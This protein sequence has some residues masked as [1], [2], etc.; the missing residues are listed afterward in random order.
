MITLESTRRWY[1]INDPVH[2]Y[3]HIERVY[4]MAI[5]LAAAEGADMGIV[6]AASLLHDVTSDRSSD[7]NSQIPRRNHQQVASE[8]A[9]QILETEGWSEARI[10]AV[11]HCI[12]AHRFRD[13]TQQP[14]TLEAK[15]IFD[16]DKL[17]AI[18]AIG[19]ARAI[20]FAVR[21]GQPVYSPPSEQ[22]LRSG[23]L[24]PGEYHS[25]YHEYVFKLCKIKDRLYTI[26]A[27]RIADSRHQVMQDYFERLA[28]EWQAQL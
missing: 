2:G 12:E 16:A 23:L 8:F 11:Q 5:R 13:N 22:F 24:Q 14:Q 17:D 26:S 25:A 21:A 3:D 27:R 9:R 18:G 19:I 20:A 1:T 10:V 4:K 7:D 28:A 15:I 6:G